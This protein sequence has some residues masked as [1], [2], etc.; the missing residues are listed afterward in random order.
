[1]NEDPSLPSEPSQAASTNPA[2]AS[3][4]QN[5]IVG[6]ILGA[7]VL[8]LFL[9]VLQ[10]TGNGLGGKSEVDEL[11]DQLEAKKEALKKN[12]GATFSSSGE[13]PQDL[14]N[15]LSADSNKLAGLVTQLQAMLSTAQRDLKSSQTTVA[16]LSSQLAASTNSAAENA[17]L[18]QQLNNSLAQAAASSSAL[19]S[20]QQQYAGAPTSAQ[21][22]A[23][24]QERDAA[25]T[26]IA[27]LTQQLLG[28]ESTNISAELQKKLVDSEQMVKDLTTRNNQLR[29]DV[30]S[31]RAELDRTKLFVDSAALPAKVKELYDELQ[32]LET[33]SPEDRAI[34]YQSLNQRL[35]AHVIKEVKFLTNSSHVNSDDEE[36]IR[37]NVEKASDQ[38]FFLVVGYASTS[39]DLTNNRQLSANRAT[40]I[41]SVSNVHKKKTQT[42]QAVFLSETARFGPNQAD[43]QLCEIW[44]VRK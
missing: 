42:V 23:A 24:H 30:Q 19:Q 14:A 11:R 2:T 17:T 41:A 37:Q 28:T 18:R 21:L 5:L 38:S 7:V 35:G 20:M 13:S 43:N 32:K 39:G 16:N 10:M 6:L 3:G 44:E 33:T 26:E 40:R 27:R 25:R 34:A 29:R 1:M 12:S 4:N 22:A 31:L 8:L 15:R 36:Q 9:L